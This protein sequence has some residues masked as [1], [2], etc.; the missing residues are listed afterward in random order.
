MV[1]DQK[2]GQ[3]VLDAAADRELRAIIAAARDTGMPVLI[4]VDYKLRRG[5]RRI[6]AN[7]PGGA[8]GGAVR[9]D[10]ARR[11][12]VG[13][14]VVTHDATFSLEIERRPETDAAGPDVLHRFLLWARSQVKARRYAILFW[15]HSCGPGGLFYDNARGRQPDPLDLGE[16][17]RAMRGASLDVVLFRDCWM[18][19]LETAFQLRDVASYAIA[20]QGQVPIKGQ[21]P[22]VDLFAIMQTA[23]DGNEEAVARALAARLG[24]FLD[25]EANRS[26]L[27]DVPYA[28]LDLRGMGTVAARL[29]GFVK[30]CHA[31][32]RD[33]AL[34]KL[35]ARAVRVARPKRIGDPA[36]IDM[37]ALCSALTDAPHPL[38][39]AAAALGSALDER[40]IKWNRARTPRFGGVSAYWKPS[41]DVAA[42]S[43]IDPWMTPLLYNRLAISADTKWNRLALQPL[44]GK[45]ALDMSKDDTFGTR[46]PAARKGSKKKAA[47]KSTA[48]KAAKK[49]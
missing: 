28:L 4:Q 16:L 18:S 24:T 9:W 15:G 37:R 20:S 12:Q 40:L 14:H 8:R 5:V 36:L 26:G 44:Q 7:A 45:E 21:W 13:R 30:A 48:R 49:K 27:A 1:A 39:P 33:P 41:P 32:L 10:P 38:G 46:K 25:D 35:A 47:S 29:S 19:T 2:T 34:T 3:R 22:Y 42:E 11:R 23:T 6:A 17:E 43:L 31:A